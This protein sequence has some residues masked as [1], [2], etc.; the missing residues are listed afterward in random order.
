MRGR[1][2]TPWTPAR[3]MAHAI[4]LARRGRYTTDPNP[5]VGCVLEKA[6][7]IIGEGWHYRAGEPHAEIHALQA[8]GRKAHGATA[9][10]T[11]EPCSHHGRTPPCAEALIQAGVSR[12]VVGM[13]DPN[14]LVAG[15]GIK[16]L[17]EAGID[18]E[19]GLLEADA[20]ALNLGFIRR[21]SEGHPRVCAKLAA[22]LDGRTAMWSGESQW[23]TGASARADVQRLRAASSAIV[24][25]VETVIH[26][27]CALTVR[28]DQL[29]LPDAD[30]IARRQP[31][32]VIVDSGLRTPIGA[33]ILKQPGT[34]LIVASQDHA[35][36]DMAAR[37]QALEE[38]GAEVIVL[39]AQAQG[40]VELK[41]L[42]EYLAQQRDCNEVLVEAG[43]TLVGACLQAGL[44]DDIYLY[45]APVLLGQSARA[46][47]NLPGLERMADKVHLKIH[48]IR[49]VGED[50]RIQ[51]SP[52]SVAPDMTIEDKGYGT[53]HD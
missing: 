41:G 53:E 29:A 36:L 7:R 38:A 33:R 21:M 44:L 23:I 1:R 14:P 49:A 17:R 6:G 25:G 5:R 30:E 34:T 9:Y 35:H 11:L 51:A 26:D 18:V 46:L 40:R 16:R 12:V 45:L 28:A 20:E 22:S 19:V 37:Q 2:K 8:A 48:D 10:V 24:T 47:F 27:D 31:L 42:F 4:S 3:C 15:N 43:A 39:P 13:Q 50:W 32:R 52:V